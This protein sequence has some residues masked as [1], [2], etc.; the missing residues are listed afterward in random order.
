V[1]VQVPTT[2]D[3]YDPARVGMLLGRSKELGLIRAF[4]TRTADSG[5][6]LLLVGDAGLGKT[7]LLNEAAHAAAASGMQVMRAGGVEFESDLVFAGLNQAFLPLVDDFDRLAGE[8]NHVLATAVGLR[9]GRLPG[10]SAVCNAVLGLLRRA[11]EVSPVV[12]IVDDLQWLDRLSNEVLSFVGRRVEGG[13]VG[14]LVAGR[15]GGRA[16]IYR[17][18]W[19]THELAPLDNAAARQLLESRFPMLTPGVRRRLLAEAAGNPLAL[20]ELPTALSEGQCQALQALP[21]VLPLS[22]RL[23]VL[24]G[25]PVA[26]L[27]AATRDLLLLAVLDGSCDLG[28]LQATTRDQELRDLWPAEQADLVHVDERSSRLE[29]RHPLIRSAVVESANRAQRRQSHLVLARM[30]AEDPDRRA[31]HLAEAATM[32][33]EDVAA[34]LEAAAR[35]AA[36]DD[37]PAGAARKLTRAAQLSPEPADRSRRQADAAVFDIRAGELDAAARLL[38][39]PRDSCADNRKLLQAASTTAFLQLNSDAEIDAAHRMLADAMKACGDRLEASD[40]AVTTAVRMLSVLSYFTGRAEP[41][42]E[43][44]AVCDGLT[45]GMPDDLY[46][47]KS[48]LPDPV[49]TAPSVLPQLDAAIA[50][51]HTER[52]PWRVRAVAWVA[53]HMDRFA[54]CRPLVARDLGRARET[55]AGSVV[56]ATLL[57]LCL[58]DFGTGMWEKLESDADAC[59]ATCRNYDLPVYVTL[60]HYCPALMAAA[61]GDDKEA[62]D[63]ADE[64]SR[65][66]EPRRADLLVDLAERARALT[67]LGR[68][69]FEAAYRH[70]AAISPAGSLLPYHR[71]A[72]W[73]CFDLVDA[74]THAG[75]H[76]EAA[77]HADAL[78]AAGIAGLSGRLSLLATGSAA[79][80]ASDDDLALSLFERALAT[81]GIARWPFDRARVQLAYGERLRRARSTTAAAAQLAAAGEGFRRLRA[82]PWMHRASRELRAT[83][84]AS[85]ALAA[86]ATQEALTTQQ[87]RIATLAAEGLTNKEIGE[88]LYL[89]PRTVS[90]HLYRLYPKLGVSS[91]GALREALKQI[92]SPSPSQDT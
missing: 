18:G 57:P 46:L 23:Q 21:P 48:T 84:R 22:R 87:Q 70:A 31:W 42:Q 5:A 9:P 45:P 60:G 3:R 74:A 77:A 14:L 55:G 83:G 15:P 38:P 61:R 1:G 75:R 59:M 49:R 56:A 30:L 86:A 37:D 47:M 10:R 16:I 34:L 71:I 91:R 85:P 29:F 27:P 17:A 6:H 2:N 32:P 69:D 68:G 90:T 81:P 64:I 12:L 20:L 58:D 50:S 82:E 79:I 43:W 76:A 72:P 63:L 88:R 13:Q 25:S 8:Y 33:D 62:R 53:A 24:F 44:E 4:L 66:A 78:Q 11:S 7:A 51:L 36:A 35:R 41:W 40:E 92:R 28:V 73:A 54:S 67:A 80:A 52:N 65:W 26:A 39:G 89:S 19:P